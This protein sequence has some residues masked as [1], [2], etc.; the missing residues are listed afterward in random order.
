MGYHGFSLGS[1]GKT[2]LKAQAKSK[3][4][5][6]LERGVPQ[7]CHHCWHCEGIGKKRQTACKPGSVHPV[8]NAGRMGRPFLWDMP[9]GMPLAANPGDRTGNV[10]AVES[11][12]GLPL[13]TP[14]RPCSRWGLPC[15]PCCQGRGALLPHRF[16]LTSAASRA[17]GLISVA[18]S[19]RSPSLAV[20]QHRIP[21]EPGLSSSPGTS[22][23]PAAAR[24]SDATRHV[25]CRPGRV[26][27]KIQA[28]QG[29]EELAGR[30]KNE[31]F[32]RTPIIL[33]C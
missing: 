22:P 7:R 20:D 25:R 16:T 11:L 23:G 18:L 9:R 10:P 5:R 31:F 26:N 13:A 2:P 4:N 17:G 19:L 3:E 12:A 30:G 28:F 33:F 6:K 8:G 21:V 29:R 1:K 14:I 15:R 32:P 27:G 24:P